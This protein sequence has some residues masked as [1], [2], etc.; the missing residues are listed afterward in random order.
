MEQPC[1]M[2]KN[3]I[4][5][6]IEVLRIKLLWQLTEVTF[7]IVK[8]W[9]QHT[10]IYMDTV[11]AIKINQKIVWVYINWISYWDPVEILCW[12]RTKISIGIIEWNWT[13]RI[14]SLR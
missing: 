3:L 12:V 10:D 5:T 6:R 13:C 4:K 7:D 11:G 2:I 9:I 8:I 1:D 14:I